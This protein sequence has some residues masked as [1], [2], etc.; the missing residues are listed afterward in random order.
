MDF[1]RLTEKSQEAIRQAQ[2]V[3]VEHGNQQVDVEHLLLALLEQEGG[4]AS[5]ILLR[6]DVALEPLH[7]RLLQEI[8]KFPKMSGGALR[9]DQVYITTRLSQL[10]TRAEEQA[11]RL[12]DEY[13]SIEHLLLAA[14]DDQG[15]AGKILRESGLTRDRLMKALVEV[16]GNQRVTTQNPEATYEA[17]QKYGRD[18]TDAASKGK[19]DPVIG[20]DEE[21]RRVIQVL[22]RRTKNNP[23]LIGEPGVGKTAIV[24]GLAQRIVRGDVP[25]GLKDKQV[26]ALDMGALIAGA[27]FRGEFE[28]RLKAVLKEV[29]SSEGRVILF[30]DELHTVV[31]AGK[32]EG[33]MDAGNLLKPMLARG[34]LHCI[35]ATT[36]DEYR[37]YIEKD[38]ALERRFQMVFVDQPTVEDTISILRG[39]RERYELHHGVRIKDTALV[40][41]AV[42]SNR[43]ISDRFL[44]DKAIDLVDEAAAKLRT[45]IDSMPAELDEILRRTMQLEI[46]REALKKESDSV[47]KDRLARIERELAELKTQS[48]ALQ[49][50]WQNEKEAVDRVRG[51]KTQIEQVKVEIAQAERAYDLNKAAE[52]KYGRLTQLEAQLK[53]EEQRAANQ[54][55]GSRLL[56]EEVDEEDIAD[57]VSRWT[58]V[59]V[60]KLLEGE[61]KKLLALEDELHK[62]VIGQ[63]EAVLAVAEAVIRARSGLKDPRRP[64]GS[65]L[66][67]GPTGV[68]KTELARAL[69]EFLFDDE[70]AMIRIDMSE[71]QE[72]HTVS[73]LI[74]APPGYIGYDDGG[75]LTEAVRRRPYSVVLFDEIEKAHHDVFNALLQVLDDGRL[76]D[77]QG[78]TVDFKNVIVILTSNIGSH[79]ILDYRGAFEGEEYR[80]M[81]EAVLSE[82]RIAFRPEFLNRL[83]EIIVFHALSEEHLKKIVEIQLAGL[84]ARLEERK[85]QL[86]LTDAAR[87]RLVRSGYDPN[88]GARPLKRA[89]QR[90]IETP[91]AKKIL[92]GEV[93]DGQRIRLD[94]DPH[95]SGLEFEVE[96]GDR[97]A[98]ATH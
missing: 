25:E 66:F 2:S 97:E 42:M 8:E 59:P 77:G 17:L 89:I 21:I 36:L 51:I 86:E 27:K 7:K 93:R 33:A 24:E 28:E 69:A 48:T 43:Y 82:L 12:K 71:Y 10:F 85:V 90:D 95:G 9:A 44:P 18:L 15:A 60:S 5:S 1:N 40:A 65:F 53:A 13:V 81:K 23:V 84:R 29:Q 96:T 76:T 75:Q 37:K 19:L 38:A 22:S 52:L 70:R 67:L 16:R 55:G 45:E 39:L 73:R 14:A 62:R 83:D 26:V 6:A 87:T 98:V 4:L 20:R 35:G 64:I 94:A 72:K 49:A 47:S 78:R 11:K 50:Q 61:M 63:D 68:G 54:Q 31:G 56:K 92:G 3:A 32:A 91:L 41:A 58:G 74:G 57:V 79:R 80:K 30:I 46:E 88:Y 34:E